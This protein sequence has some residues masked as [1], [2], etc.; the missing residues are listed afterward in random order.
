MQIFILFDI[1]HRI[2]LTRITVNLDTSV[3]GNKTFL[4]FPDNYCSDW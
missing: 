2:L 1:S 4:K 3:K